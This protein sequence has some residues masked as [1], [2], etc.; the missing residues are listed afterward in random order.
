M[1]TQIEPQASS[2]SNFVTVLAWIFIVL[3]GF[4]TLIGVLQNIMVQT[5]FAD[6]QFNESLSKVP[7]GAP[8]SAAFMANNIRLMFAI[9][10]GVFATTLVSSIGLLNRRN[11]ARIIF[12]G[13]MGLGILWNIGGLVFQFIMFSSFPP[14]S[15]A[16]H[17]PA[18]FQSMFVGMLVFG[19][20]LAIAI[21]V[22]FGW[23]IKRLV[24]KPI[25]AEFGK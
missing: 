6:P 21:S 23:V 15:Q 2:K 12:I 1:E 8:A 7:S 9:A 14:T 22:L 24:S 3:S 11:W 16:P 17:E 13:I 10:L 18:A 4:A 25:A 20:C 5:M 19:A